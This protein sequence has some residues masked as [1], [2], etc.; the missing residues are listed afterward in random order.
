LAQIGTQL[1]NPLRWERHYLSGSS[2]RERA[3][4]P[5]PV[6]PFDAALVTEQH[7]VLSS[8]AWNDTLL[9]LGGWQERIVAAN[10][11]VSTYFYV[12]W[13]AI[14]DKYH[15]TRWIAYERAAFHV[16]QCITTYV[17]E[18][19]ARQGLS[20]RIATIPANLA[21]AYLVEQVHQGS[22]L[23]GM[24]TAGMRASLDGL[25]TD[26]VHLT[27]LGSFYVAVVS[28]MG[29]SGLEPQ[30]PGTEQ[31]R[32]LAGTAIRFFNSRAHENR[33]MRVADCQRYLRTSFLDDYLSYSRRSWWN[34]TRLR[35]AMASSPLFK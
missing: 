26:N 4:L 17:N 6:G 32:F 18:D 10:P 29:M 35:R 8:L 31:E 25:F 12:P 22:R 9:Q 7:D 13:L 24:E 3:A 11:G 5:D 21:L 28:Y 33:A 16:W 2:I 20:D 27:R 15:P 14:D 23:P 30:Q 19:R 34:A 1:G